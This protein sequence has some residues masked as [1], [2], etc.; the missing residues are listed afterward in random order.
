MQYYGS[1]TQL[2]GTL[3]LGNIDLSWYRFWYCFYGR[4]ISALRYSY[5]LNPRL[6]SRREMVPI[7]FSVGTFVF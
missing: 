3:I 7:K 2:E 4:H 5:V 6:T 1:I